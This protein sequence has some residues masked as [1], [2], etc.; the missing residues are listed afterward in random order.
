MTRASLTIE[1][2]DASG[3]SPVARRLRKTGRVPG[4]LYTGEDN[5]E[6]SAD[7]LE[8]AAVIRK[9]ATLI[10]ADYEGTKH[11]TVLKEYQ[12]HP[13]RGALVHVDLQAVSMD[14][15]VRTVVSITVEGESPGIKQGGILTEGARELNIESTAATIPDTIRIDATKVDLGEVLIL[16][17]LEAPEGATFLDDEGMM[18]IAITVPRGAKGKAGDEEAEALLDAEAAAAAGTEV[19]VVTEEVEGGE[20]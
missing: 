19:P 18:L 8:L 7:A 10:D 20:G 3:K 6:F 1:K 15:K 11:L 5:Y 12:L 2:R 16:R 9:G 17:D 14:Q 4:V 13:V